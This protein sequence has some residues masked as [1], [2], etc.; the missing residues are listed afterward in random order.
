MASTSSRALRIS[1]LAVE[2]LLRL[3]AGP[4]LLGEGGAAI[5]DLL[6]LGFDPGELF[7]AERRVALEVVVK[8]VLDHRTDGD[9]R[10]RPQ[11]LHRLGEHVRGVVADQAEAVGAVAHDEFDAAVLVQRIGKVR[12]DAVPLH[13]DG[14]LGEAQGDALDHG[15]PGGATRIVAYCTVW[16]RHLDHVYL[17]S[18]RRNWRV[19]A[20]ITTFL[21][22]SLA[23]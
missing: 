1:P 19:R 2:D 11:L 6:H 21:A 16:E 17:L 14:A 4:D 23:V 10:R 3:V 15:G 5:D 18:R 22:M 12:E 20:L 13:R 8:A 9:L 7:L